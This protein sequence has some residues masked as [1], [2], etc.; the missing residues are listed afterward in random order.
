MN[1]VR[2]TSL[3]SG[4]SL[5]LLVSCSGRAGA[6]T[7]S[8]LSTQQ[9]GNHIETAVFAGGCFW[10]MEAVFESLNGV[11]N[12]ASGY[13]G[14]S[15]SDAQYR[16]VGSGMTG[17]AESILVTYDSQIIDYDRLLTV[18]FMVAHNPTELNY[19]GP[20]HG[21][22][23]R[24]AV[25]YRTPEQK[26]AAERY[27]EKLKLDRIWPKPVV[28][29]LESLGP[30]YAAE[31]Y[32]QNFLVN[33]KTYPYIVQFDI[34]KLMDLVHR[35]PDLVRPDSIAAILASNASGGSDR[36]HGYQI[37]SNGSVVAAPIQRSDTEWKQLL[38]S[39]PYSVLR[40]A[41][42]ERS[43]SGEL[44]DEHRS[45]TF[46]SAATGQPLFRSETKFESGTGWPSFSKPIDSTA[47]VMRWDLEVGGRRVEVLDSS[48]AS[49]LGHVFDD[50][51]GKT[52]AFPAGTGLR[53]C[54]NSVSLLFVADGDVLPAL[55]NNYLSEQGLTRPTG[56]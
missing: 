10:G 42:T 51:P 23:Y 33:N 49:H 50:G 30:F 48:S 46:F 16:L 6:Q 44:L 37:R 4:F 36:W 9:V 3:L 11:S 27:I 1:K 12:V 28:T 43:Y 19:Q 22:Q 17:H 34:P 26:A 45:G 29:K 39:F 54:M 13:T 24:S 55:V 14:G 38:G 25:F 41:A 32:H 20:D 52:A 2:Y 21:T 5:L 35:Y 18:F 47:I 56:Q 40:A 7:A 31:D 8:V 15:A 53:F